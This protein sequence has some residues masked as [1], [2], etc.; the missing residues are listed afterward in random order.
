[1]A[2]IAFGAAGAG[3]VAGG[4]FTGL[5]LYA[6]SGLDDDAY[7]H[8]KICPDQASYRDRQ[9]RM[10]TFAD[11]ATAGFALGILGAA[12]G[13]YFWVVAEPSRDRSNRDMTT[14]VEGW[15]GFGSAGLATTF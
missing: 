7:C 1:V 11:L 4:V 2:F 15:I 3:F 5:A 13:T 9:S 6:K 10:R 8:D 14:R 12:A